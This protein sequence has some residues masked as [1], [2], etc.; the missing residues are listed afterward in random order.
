[1][2]DIGFAETSL[3]VQEGTDA[4][5]MVCAEITV[6]SGKQLGC[7]I[8]VTFLATNGALASE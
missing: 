7:D 8:P 3:I 4:L 1:M 5:V 2:I 6:P